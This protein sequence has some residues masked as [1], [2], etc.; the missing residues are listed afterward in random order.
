MTNRYRNIFLF[1]GVAAI[2]V[3]LFSFDMSWAEVGAH[4][5]RAGYWFPA[6]IV[7]WLFIYIINARAWQIIVNEGNRKPRIGFLRIFKYTVS[8][9]A[10]NS[11]TPVGLLGGEPYRIMELSPLVGRAKATSSVI[12]YAMMHIFSHFCFWIFSLGVFLVRYAHVLSLPMLIVLGA[13]LLFCL[14]GVKFFVMGYRY[15]LVQKTVSVFSR[16]PLVGA[17]IQRVAESHAEGLQT[18]DEQIS[19]LHTQRPLVFYRSLFLEFFARLVGCFELQFI[20]FIFNPSISYWDCLLMQAFVSLFANLFFFIP[21]Q[22]GSK[23]GGLAIFTS[24]LHMNGSYG[25]LTG[26]IT[27]L[28][29]LIW[30]AIGLLLIRFGNKKQVK[31]NIF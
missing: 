10:L 22:M 9:Y 7:L 4:V 29:E 13:I 20:L 26:L 8:G 15:G 17:R 28:R 23:E 30:I 19:A 3:M 12:L 31:S 21:M 18:V 16:L 27:R 1:I 2:A 11:V 5:R 25:V 14:V 6:V 24:V